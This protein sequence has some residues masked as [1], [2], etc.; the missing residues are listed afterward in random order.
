LGKE[1]ASQ[2]SVGTKG[3]WGKVKTTIIK[4][5]QKQGGGE[6][7]GNIHN[8]KNTSPKNKER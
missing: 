3:W 5:G 4:A 6:R 2:G 7:G 8:D 1:V